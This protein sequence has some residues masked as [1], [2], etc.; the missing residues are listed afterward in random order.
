MKGTSIV[1][2][3]EVPTMVSSG[4]VCKMGVKTRVKSDANNAIIELCNGRTPVTR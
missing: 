4:D 2:T 1:S 3:D